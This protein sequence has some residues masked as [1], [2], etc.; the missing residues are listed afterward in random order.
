MITGS[1]VSVSIPQVAVG[2]TIKA[3]VKYTATNPG[4][5][6]WKTWLIGYSSIL[7]L[8]KILDETRE[9]GS[10]GGRTKTFSLGSQPS[11]TVGISF[12]LFASDN[13]SDSFNWSAFDTWMYYGYGLPDNIEYLGSSYAF[14]TPGSAGLPDPEFR[15][16]VVTGATSPVGVGDYCKISARWE[17]RGPAI[18][19]TIYGAIGN[20]GFWGFDEVLHNQATLTIPEKADWTAMTG[21]ILIPITA[22]IDPGDSPYDV[23][24]KLTGTGNDLISSA[25]EDI[26]VISGS[27]VPDSQARNLVITGYNAVVDPGAYCTLQVSFEYKGPSAALTLKGRIGNDGIWGFDVILD[28]SKGIS[29]PESLDWK[30]ITASISIYIG[31]GISP[32]D[33]P[34]DLKAYLTGTNIDI[35]S[36]TLADVLTVTGEDPVPDSEFRNLE[37][38]G[39][40]SPVNIGG[41]CVIK[42]RYQYR[43]PAVSKTLYAAIGNNGFWGFDEILAAS[44]TINIAQALDWE[45][46][47][48]TVSITITDS[49]DPDDG[50]YDVYAKLTGAANDIESPA[51]EDVIAVNGASPDPQ[52]RNL[53]VLEV[54]SPIGI[55]GTCWVKCQYE[56]IGPKATQEIYAAIGNDGAWGF[57]EILHVSGSVDLPACPAW[58]IITSELAIEIT[59]EIDPADSPYDVYFK[60]AGVV[61]P[62]ATDVLTVEEGTGT[63]DITGK[64][65]A[66]EP[67]AFN[68]A[69]KVDIYVSFKAYC[70]DVIQQING[71]ST[72]VTIVL[73]GLTGYDEQYHVGRDGSRDLQKI[74]VGD[75]PASS[76]TGKVTLEGRGG[77][78]WVLLDQKDISVSLIGGE[79][80]EEPGEEGGGGEGWGWVVL[81]GLGILALAPNGSS[82]KP[83]KKT[84]AKK[85]S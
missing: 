44:K 3:T 73:G 47:E 46:L 49:L 19:K 34:Y 82:E 2:E 62:T 32:E 61:S 65:T 80:P 39:Y 66:A 26:V 75:M 84:K 21:S 53:S 70:D 24:V 58:Q 54:T 48:A 43:G 85:E 52:Y 30:T 17:Y 57:D 72:R 15:N 28:S 76:L 74:E 59:G 20:N 45:E 79:T 38:T 5:L 16:L 56:Y 78:D 63:G 68:F 13:A 22:A 77:G 18:N 10:D 23:Y 67:L 41:A 4:A 37:V 51:L 40:T 9:I 64:L 31:A 33:S 36:P 8:K 81:A 42:V 35:Y 83:K 27:S 11:S 55:G 29:V 60:V 71:W 12:F 50:P 1:I 25:Y 7:G 6:Y 14:A 69:D